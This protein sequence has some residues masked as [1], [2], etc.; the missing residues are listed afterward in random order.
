MDTSPYYKLLQS[1]S[2][3]QIKF[4]KFK[5][6]SRPGYIGESLLSWRY[7]AELTTLMQGPGRK[8]VASSALARRTERTRRSFATTTTRRT[9]GRKS[10]TTPRRRTLGRKG[11]SR[12]IQTPSRTTGCART[13]KSTTC[14]AMARRTRSRCKSTGTRTCSS[15]SRIRRRGR[16]SLIARRRP[17]RRRTRRGRRT[18]DRSFLSFSDRLG[19]RRS[20]RRPRCS[21]RCAFSSSTVRPFSSP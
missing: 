15:S 13:T 11:S 14:P 6:D 19:R 20:G 12:R 2:K 3:V 5:E 1:R 18:P 16:R 8:R 9:N 17:R 21:S 7:G 4:L 10:L